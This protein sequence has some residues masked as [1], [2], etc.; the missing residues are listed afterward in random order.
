MGL[1]EDLYS[2][3]TP[4]AEEGAFRGAWKDQP[5]RFAM[6]EKGTLF[7]D[8]VGDIRLAKKRLFREVLYYRLNV[9]RVELPPL[10]RRR[11]DIP[12]LVDH[13]IKWGRKEKIFDF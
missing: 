10:A 9:V 8:E 7:L 6:A 2:R 5:G 13:F 3:V 12:L 11:E 1:G 4:R